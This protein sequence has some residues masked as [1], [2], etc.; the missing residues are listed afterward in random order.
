[1]SLEWTTG[2][3]LGKDGK[4]G[5]TYIGTLKRRFKGSVLDMPVQL[6]K[7]ARVAVKTFR[8]KKS[9][10]RIEKESTLQQ[11]CAKAGIS[12]QVYGIDADKK[13][14]VMQMLAS[15]PVETYREQELPE[16]L[17]YQI[18]ALMHRLDD[19][20]V[21]HNDMNAHNVMLDESGRPYMI[22]FGLAKPIT[23]AVTKK[24]GDAP[25][26]KVTLWGL[27]RGFKR[28]KV[29]CP[30]MEQCLKANDRSKFYEKGESY[31]ATTGHRR[32]RR[33]R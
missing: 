27:V 18:C 1:M 25:N 9:V 16:D 19:A 5:I 21:L 11:K 33:K 3:Q 31:F 8:A 2:E 28:S 30:I 6:R 26:I 29:Q 10:A 22:D 13:C 7:G 23:G 4:E 17:Q 24:F 20:K 14:I 12:P 15:L 32:K